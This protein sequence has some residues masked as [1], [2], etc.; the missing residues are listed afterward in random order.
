MNSFNIKITIFLAIAAHLSLTITARHTLPHE[1]PS[2]EERVELW[3]Q[4]NTWPPGF[5]SLNL[6]NLISH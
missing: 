1:R 2:E 4:R 3:R 6:L 5:Y